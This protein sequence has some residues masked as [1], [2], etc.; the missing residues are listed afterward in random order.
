MHLH[1]L[2]EHSGELMFV[3][4]FLFD[5]LTMQR[6]DAWTDLA[7]Q[8]AYLL[9]LTLLLVYQQRE[10]TGVWTPSR[11]PS[12]WSRPLDLLSRYN[13]D[14][15]HFLYGGLLSAYVVLYLRSSTFARPA[16]F[17]VLLV[18]VM[19]VNEFPHVRRAG[20]ALRL[21]LYSFCVL[22]FFNYF[23]PVLIGRIGGWIF[24]VSLVA[25]AVIV[26][27][28][29]SWLAPRGEDRREER[30]RLFIPA[31]GVLAFVGVLYV[32]RLIPPVPLSVQFQGIYHEVHRDQGGY[33]LVYE[34][35]PAWAVWRHDSRPFE[36]RAGDR[37]HYFAR[38]F[39]PDRF[40]HRVM[41]RWEVYS[42]AGSGWI[43]TDRI[44]LEIVGGRT[45]GFRGTAVKSNFMPGRWRVT[46][47]TEDGRALATLTFRVED[48]TSGRERHWKTARA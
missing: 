27:R 42:P 34:E 39:A 17:L 11:L 33:T 32:L 10:A 41:I 44:P 23:I 22:S 37:L 46:A 25:S 19:I 12:P 5:L 40:R 29:T 45:E 4:G 38:V 1:R 2:R 18:G 14:A 9:G 26:W 31:I 35:P 47:E 36:R 20:Y 30:R 6:I 15:L 8:L 3:A 7:I 28:V 43:T 48:D 13:V 16:I 21:G 24:L